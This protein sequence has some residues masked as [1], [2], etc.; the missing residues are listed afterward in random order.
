[1]LCLRSRDREPGGSS[2]NFRLRLNQPIQGCYWLSHAMI[3]NSSFNVDQHNSTIAV[4]VDG[5]VRT[6][7]VL[8]GHHTSETL[9]ARLESALRQQVDDDL[10]V[11]QVALTLRVR[12]YMLN[13]RMFRLRFQDLPNSIA[14]VLGFPRAD[15]VLAPQH[16]GTELLDLT[17]DQLTFNVV[18]SAPGVA[19]GITN[20][21]GHHSSFQIANEE[22]SL[23]YVSWNENQFFPQGILFR[24]PVRELRVQLVDADFRPVDLQGAEWH[25][26]WRPAS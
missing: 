16:E 5:E 2:S 8:P 15:S 12:I 9:I 22:N 23:E 26:L 18:V 11:Q 14:P 6:A 13:G 17:H 3:P 7:T 24:S 4:E 21:K 19:F 20:S 10:R 25:M 1:M